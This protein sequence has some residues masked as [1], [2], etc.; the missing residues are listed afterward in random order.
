M[1]VSALRPQTLVALAATVLGLALVLAAPAGGGAPAASSCTLTADP[2][3][4]YAGMVFAPASVEC[5]APQSKLRVRTQ[6]TRDGVAVAENSRDCHKTARCLNT[7]GSFT[8]DDAGDQLWCTTAW[9]WVGGQSVG[10]ATRCE[11]EPF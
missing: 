11:A 2:P 3:F 7:V 6:L 4:F 10:S 9:G 8:I 1:S 5:T